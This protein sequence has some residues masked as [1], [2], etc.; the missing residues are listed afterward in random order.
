M[1][2]AK[3]SADLSRLR[4]GEIRSKECTSKFCCGERQIDQWANGKAFKHHQQDRARVFCAR[5][6]DSATVIAFYSLS[7]SQFGKQYLFGQD[8]D[9]Y[10]S[11]HAPFIYIDWFAVSRMH[12]S[13]GIGRILMIDALKR[14]HKVSQEIPFYGVALRSLNESTTAFYRA[15]G[16]QER[17]D[18]A[19]P[20][21]I[22]PV[23]TIR[24]LFVA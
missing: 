19:N 1:M 2:A 18:G 4:I 20:L 9:R 7:L 3:P 10:H 6:V 15:I 24:D 21:M 11:G 23:W 16:F 14:A 17:E 13:S 5:F 12:Q 8:G 22:L